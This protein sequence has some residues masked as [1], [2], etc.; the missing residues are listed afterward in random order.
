MSA[1][2]A[3]GGSVE[4]SRKGPGQAWVNAVMVT[5]LERSRRLRNH[6]TC[7]AALAGPKR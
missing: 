5:E 1:R 4:E 2:E 7:T 3:D 6:V